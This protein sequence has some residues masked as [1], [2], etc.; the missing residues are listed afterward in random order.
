MNP[1]KHLALGSFL[2]LIFPLANFAQRVDSIDV[3]HYNLKVNLQQISTKKIQG[4]AQLIC[5]AKF[6]G[7]NRFFLDLQ[8]LT[9]D[10]LAIG[11]KKQLFT[12]SDSTILVQ[13]ENTYNAGDTIRLDVFYQGSP[14]TD[15]KWGGFYFSNNFAY[16]MGVGMGSNPPNFGRCWF[17]CIDNFIDRATYEFHVTTD[18]GFMAVCSGLQSP[19]TLHQNGSI[20]WHWNLSQSIPTYIANVAVSKYVLIESSYPGLKR[21]IPVVLA[22]S[23]ADT[24][25]LKSSFVRLSN[26]MSCFEEKFGPYLFDRVGFVGVPF[27]AGAMEHACNISYPL[28]AVDGAATYETLMAHELS[29][30]WWGNLVTTRTASDM[31]LNEGWASYCEALFLECAYGKNAY[32][33]KIGSELFDALRNA[34][35]R[36]QGYKPVSGVPLAQTYGTHVYTKGGL[37]VHNLRLLMGDQAFFDACKSYLQVFAF[38]DANSND[39]KNEFQKFTSYDLTSFFNSFIFDKGHLDAQFHQTV[40]GNETIEIHGN[41]MSRYKSNFANR[42]LLHVGVYYQNGSHKVFPFNVVSPTSAGPV[43]FGMEKS[44]L[45]NVAFIVLNE[46]SGMALGSISESKWIKNTGVHNFTQALFTATVQSFG[47]SSF[48]HVQHHYAGPWIASNQLPANVIVSKER[49]WEINGIFDDNFKSTAFFN[50]DGTLNTRLDNELIQVTED[51][52]VL[53]YRAHPNA[54]FEI[55]SD[56][57][58]QPGPSKTDK[59]GRF[60]LNNLKAGQY[61]IGYRSILAGLQ[62]FVEVPGLSAYPNPSESGKFTLEFPPMQKAAT[63]EIYNTSGVLV[64]T[65]VIEKNQHQTEV[66]LGNTNQNQIYIAVILSGEKRYSVKLISK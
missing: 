55:V 19:A 45:E 33:E 47:D 25:K 12:Q 32:D 2:C 53:L 35:V 5:L 56:L 48:L 49:F 6:N 43:R 31:W 23:P 8:K 21:N 62:H 66:N 24:L 36:D 44:N 17:P 41:I 16:N 22:I 11:S 40:N 58:F 37:M 59:V 39:L 15:S 1:F 60:W 51:S 20:T 42:L 28:Y 61:A 50:Y 7:L 18:T 29:H 26:A 54:P 64:Q 9:V 3:L 10:S 57:T 52:L 4:N 30:H 14:V 65:K 46:N 38:K 27:N 63:L 13:T 34:T